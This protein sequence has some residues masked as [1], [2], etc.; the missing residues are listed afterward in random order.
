MFIHD[1]DIQNQTPKD[2][3]ILT[4]S[5]YLVNILVVFIVLLRLLIILMIYYT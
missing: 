4:I 2:E 1:F 3:I 5:I